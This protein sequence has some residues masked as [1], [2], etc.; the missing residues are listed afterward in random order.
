MPCSSGCGGIT[1]GLPT[2]LNKYMSK[3]KYSIELW[4]HTNAWQRWFEKKNV[5]VNVFMGFNMNSRL[6]V[7]VK[8]DIYQF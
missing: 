1:V 7:D 4:Q 2:F 5:R 6:F 8:I 3:K